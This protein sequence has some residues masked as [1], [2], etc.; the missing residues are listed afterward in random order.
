MGPTI[1]ESIAYFDACRRK[2]NH[3]EAEELLSNASDFQ[4]AVEAWIR[5][6]HPFLCSSEQRRWSIG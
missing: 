4:R 5:G 3:V 1:A 6:R 2:R